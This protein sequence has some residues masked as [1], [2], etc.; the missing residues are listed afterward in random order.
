MSAKSA[1]TEPLL[2]AAESG[3]VA[4]VADLIAS[5]DDLEV[6][7]SA[8]RTPL[9]LAATNDH[10]HVAKQ[11]IAAGADP[12]AVDDQR[13]TPWLVTGV[14]GSVEM[15]EVLAAA[16]ADLSLTNRYGG[17]SV[18]PASERGHLDYVRWVLA[19]AEIDVNH[20]N[21]LGWT[22]LLEAVILGDGSETYLEVVRALL[23]G[24]ADSA[25]ADR[26]GVTQLQHASSRGYEEIAAALKAAGQ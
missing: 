21:N 17:V 26:D 18:I 6:R 5:G 16:G 1:S 7:D 24:G 8:G 23:A 2:T 19:N 10:V 4:S 3:D 15:A 20:V 13:D 25:L 9:L 14:T 22:A 11:L 12:N